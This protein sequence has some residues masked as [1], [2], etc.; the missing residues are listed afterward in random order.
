MLIVGGAIGAFLGMGVGSLVA[1]VRG[2]AGK[3]KDEVM[4]NGSAFGG[5]TAVA[6]LIIWMAAYEL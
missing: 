5:L 6:L 1:K 4:T 2:V 3:A